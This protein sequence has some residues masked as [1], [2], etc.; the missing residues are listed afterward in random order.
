MAAMM[1]IIA[2]TISSSMSEKPFWPFVCCISLTVLLGESCSSE[3]EKVIPVKNSFSH[4]RPS[5]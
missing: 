4:W 5:S 1:P 2:T 3:E